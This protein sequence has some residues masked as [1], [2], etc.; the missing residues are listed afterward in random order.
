MDFY[1]ILFAKRR[2]LCSDYYTTLFARAI[3]GGAS[4]I[5]ETLTGTSP[6][7]IADALT[8]RIL[9]LKQYGK[10][11]QGSTPTPSSP[12]P[13]KINNG[14]LKLIDDELPSGYKRIKSIGFDGDFWYDTGKTL[15]GSDNVTITLDDTSTSGQ[16]VFGSYNGTS[17]GTKNFSL[18]LYGGG[19]S[20]N[21]YLRYG[22]QLVRPRYGNGKRTV[23]FGKDGTD[24]FATN[25]TIEEDT[26]ETVATAYIGMLPNSSS[27]AYTGTI[28]GDILV[29]GRLRYIP[30]ENPS[31]VIGYYEIE[32]GEFLAPSGTGTPDAGDYDHSHETALIVDGTPEVLSVASQTASVANLYAVGDFEDEQDVIS[33]VITRKVG[34]TVLDG[35]E[36]GWALSVSGSTNRFRGLKPTDCHTPASRAP[37]VSTHF[38]Y[39]S[40][41]STA[42]GMFIGASAYWY[43]IPTDQTL[44]TVEGWTAWLAEQYAAGTPV[45]VLYPLA[46]AVEESVTA[47]PLTL[48][49][50]DNTLT[51]TAEVSGIEFEVKY[52]KSAT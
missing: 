37:S 30:C 5:I 48:A 46:K 18:Y 38:K 9:S 13:I 32:N 45:I 25:V 27:P 12:V 47:Q 35:T 6:I 11:A 2:R 22:E 23:T 36:R 42:G 19:S 10:C 33:G 29:G 31:G 4:Y 26:F 50:G 3:G 7:S 17:S 43:F 34:I 51:A 39:L 16:N 20:S 8:G 28:V 41:G 24:G 21:C 14:T 40:T 52:K 49:E 15:L 1:D 44:D